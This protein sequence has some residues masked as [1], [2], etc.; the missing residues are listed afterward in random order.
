MAALRLSE[1]QVEVSLNYIGNKLKEANIN[2]RDTMAFMTWVIHNPLPSMEEMETQ[3]AQQQID[4][5]AER[6]AH[7]RAQLAKLEDN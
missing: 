3:V 5:K 1:E 6:I 7:H 4:R 2:P